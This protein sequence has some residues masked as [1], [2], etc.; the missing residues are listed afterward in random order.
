MRQRISIVLGMSYVVLI[1]GGLS[2]GMFALSGCGKGD[3]G[4][5]SNGSAAGDSGSESDSGEGSGEVAGEFPRMDPDGR[6]WLEDGMPLNVWYPDPLAVAKQQGTVA[7][8]TTD[9][10]TT[11][12]TGGDTPAAEP[13]PAE[14]GGDVNW[15][16]VVAATVLDDEV[17]KISNRFRAKLQTLAT[18]NSSYL[19]LPTYISSM[20][21]LAAIAAE[22]PDDIRWKDDAKK[23]RDLS[24]KMLSEKLQ[25]GAKSYK[26]VN[27]PYLAITDI[28]RGS[29]PGGLPEPNP[30]DD[31]VEYAE[32]GFL[33]KRFEVGTKWLNVNAGTEDALKENAADIKHE[34]G[35]LAA[36]ATAITTEGYGYVDD[37]EF[38]GFAKGMIDGCKKVA[39]AV[40]TGSLENYQLGFSMID[41]ACTKCH[42]SYR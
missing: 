32:M 7:A 33:M 16:D 30:E 6:V 39:E 2:L 17:K 36:L 35:V 24:A 14:S 31:F 12:E 40:G 23:I 37:G 10:G 25:R 38:K 29:T 9:G 28:L 34:V 27:E 26:Q 18:Y 13:P 11:P 19:E 20:A 1:A 42:S 5:S 22:H 41:Q 21:V 8:P 4:G 15:K 3:S